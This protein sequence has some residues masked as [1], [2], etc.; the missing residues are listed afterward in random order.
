MRLTLHYQCLSRLGRCNQHPL[1]LPAGSSTLQLQPSHRRPDQH[2]RLDW[3]HL[4]LVGR[5]LARRP[6]FGPLQQATPGN[7][8]A[9]VE[10]TS[11]LGSGP[12]RSCGMFGFRL[13]RRG[14][15]ALDFIVSDRLRPTMDFRISIA[16]F[17]PQILRLRHGLRRPDFRPSRNNDL[18]QRLL[19]A[20]QRRCTFTRQWTQGTFFKWLTNRPLTDITLPVQ[21]IVAFGF[22]HGV[23]GWVETGYINAFGTQAGIYVAVL[24]L[25]IPLALYGERIRHKTAQW[26]IIM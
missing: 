8:P 16:N 10:T 2:P 6:L 4:W 21:N 22:L 1:S 3:K 12:H 11:A 15:L 13:W 5:R 24:A 25:A 19:P 14:R 7:F 18:C 23:N 20:R 9:G 17:Q 26:R